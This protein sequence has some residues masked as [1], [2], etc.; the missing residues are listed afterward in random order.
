M[1]VFM[2]R[3][4]PFRSIPQAP[5]ASTNSS[6]LLILSAKAQRRRCVGEIGRGASGAIGR[7]GESNGEPRKKRCHWG[8]RVWWE[9]S[10]MSLSRFRRLPILLAKIL[11][12]KWDLFSQPV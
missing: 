11:G 2:K 1:A 7:R 4:P 12:F 5:I 3:P 9:S 10:M 8:V 6:P